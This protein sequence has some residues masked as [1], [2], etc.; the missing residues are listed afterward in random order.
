MA[1]AA[2][3]ELNDAPLSNGHNGHKEEVPAT[4]GNGVVQADIGEGNAM[5]EANWDNTSPNEMSTSQ[6][7][8]Q[9]TPR[10]V[11]ETENGVAATLAAPARIQSWAD[12][13][14]DSPPPATEVSFL[15]LTEI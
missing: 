12:E 15:N 2:F 9:V 13:K 4:N 10:D 8:V 6:E 5:A 11:T 7:W 1:N 3:T 14:P